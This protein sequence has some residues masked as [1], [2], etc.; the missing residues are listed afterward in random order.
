MVTSAQ[1]HWMI[2]GSG[3]EIGGEKE[4]QDEV[5]TNQRGFVVFLENGVGSFWKEI[6]KSVKSRAHNDVCGEGKTVERW[7]VGR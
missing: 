2:K 6:E 4:R 5:S 3:F 1:D 7:L